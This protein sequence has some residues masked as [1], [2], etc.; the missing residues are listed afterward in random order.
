MKRVL[1]AIVFVCVA[2]VASAQTGSANNKL[3]WDQPAASIAEAQSLTYKLYADGS[4]TASTLP[5]ATCTGAT[6]PYSCTV[7]F[8]A[9]TP[10]S[11]TV[12]LSASNAAGE[13][14]KSAAFGFTFVVIPASP[15]NI[16]VQ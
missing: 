15:A 16:R 8:P 12:Q 9:F 3:A 5:T 10:G 1:L 4:A 7:P 11:H 13:S 6:A 14:S 2:S